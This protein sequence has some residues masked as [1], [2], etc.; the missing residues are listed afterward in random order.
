[1]MAAKSRRRPTDEI[2]IVGV[3]GSS[4]G[5][6]RKALTKSSRRQKLRRETVRLRHVPS[7]KEMLVEIPFGHYSK[8]EMQRLREEAKVKFLAALR[9]DTG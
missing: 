5:V 6:R 4:K 3:S 8:R 7:G 9:R 1:M 2:E